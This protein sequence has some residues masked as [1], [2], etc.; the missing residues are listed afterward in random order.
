MAAPG[1]ASYRTIETTTA[2]P[3]RL[4]VLLLDGAARFLVRAQRA[5][6]RGDRTEFAQSV[7]RAN[8]IVL[9]L[10]ATLDYEAGGP[11]AVDL[12]R[13]YDFM[14]HH[15]VQGMVEHSA[16]H[17]EEVLA[18]LRPIRAGFDGAVASTRS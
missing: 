9:H 15:L 11:V 13:L 2:D 14:F 7:A 1:V 16:K 4:V 10:A 18:V 12:G 5:H 3:S 6:A 17:V 8:R